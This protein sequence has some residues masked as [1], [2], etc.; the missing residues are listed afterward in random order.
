MLKKR[1]RR[2]V[3]GRAPDF[4]QYGRPTPELLRE[5]EKHAEALRARSASQIL[6]GDPAPGYSALDQRARG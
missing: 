1:K 2:I 4:H 5:R 6:F 3:K